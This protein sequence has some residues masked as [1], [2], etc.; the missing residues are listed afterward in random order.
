MM[1]NGETNKTRATAKQPKRGAQDHANP[2]KKEKKRKKEEKKLVCM[3]GE[4]VHVNV[5]IMKAKQQH[6][7][8]VAMTKLA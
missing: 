1:M 5:A 3:T 2:T 8:S 7:G 4:G 6:P